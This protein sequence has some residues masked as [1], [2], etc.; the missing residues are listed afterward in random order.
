MT[1]AKDVTPEYFW[2]NGALNTLTAKD[3]IDPSKVVKVSWA[4]G[5]YQEKNAR[6]FPFK[7][8]RGKGPYDKVHKTMLTP[9]LSGEDGFWAMLEW[10]DAFRIGAEYLDLPYSGQYGFVETSYVFPTTHMV[11]PKENV[12]SC[13]E[14][15]VRDEGR[16]AS[17]AGFYM[18]GRDQLKTLD[19]L[20][21]AVILGSLGGVLLHGLG[22]FIANGR[23]RRA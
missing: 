5:S 20:G 18:P 19:F 3:V 17:L 12:V 9:L 13:N 6:I 21:W 2:F 8:H 1:W 10:P 22:R 4:E 14:C 15:H 16:L 7:V 11:A 23:K